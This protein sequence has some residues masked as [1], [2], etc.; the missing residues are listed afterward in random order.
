MPRSPFSARSFFRDPIEYLAASGDGHATIPLSAGPTRFLL[1]RD[2]ELV[3]RVLVTDD[4]SFAPGKWKRRARRF[5]G[6][7]LN[8]L[9]GDEHRQRRQLL[10]PPLDRR[11]IAL[12]APAIAERVA[13]AQSAWE[14][15]ARIVLRDTLDPLSLGVAGDVLLSTE[16]DPGLA[17]ELRRIIAAVP[18]LRPP[19]AG[20]AGGTA[21]G[22]V[23]RVV[24]AL[25][26][27]RAGPSEGGDLLAAL[28]RSGLPER[29]QRGEVIAFLLAA[30][31]EPPSA[32]EAAWYLL[33]RHPEAEARLHAELDAGG[34]SSYLDAVLFETLRLFPPARYIDRCPVRD[35]RIGDVH[36]KRGSNVL[37]SP[38]V[39]HADGRVYERPSAFEPER[40]LGGRAGGRG[41]YVPFGAGAH[42]CIGEPLAR[43]IMTTTLATVARRWRLRVDP[44]APLPVPSSPRLIVTLQHR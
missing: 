3:W 12:F 9:S 23:E 19:V 6:A 43:A 7:T 18:R 44:D 35:V 11:R 10:Q 31:D 13:H 14:D 40:W 20:T 16:L 38:L 26:G 24:Q 15:G 1:V 25:I 5:V 8:T 34:E 28:L 4:D 36:V 2:P 21:L 29:T 42:T 22:R 37:V 32:L 30:V 33:G 39:T 17:D 41:E 27:A